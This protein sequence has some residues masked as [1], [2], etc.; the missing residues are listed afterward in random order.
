MFGKVI[1]PVK[2]AIRGGLLHILTGNFLAK[3][4]TMLSAVLIARLVSK[5]LYA[6]YSYTT[7]LYSYVEL[8]NGLEL[9]G[10]LLVFC[11]Q[12]H[13]DNINL[14]WLKYSLRIS[15]MVQFVVSIALCITVTFASIAYPQARG[16]FYMYLLIPVG[17]TIINNLQSF[18][19]A[20][21]QNKL[22]SL[23]GVVRA[24]V[25]TVV[26]LLLVPIL[27]VKGMIIAIYMGTI[28][29]IWIGVK[30][31]VSVTKKSTII[32]ICRGEKKKYFLLAFSFLVANAFSHLIPLNE[33]FLVNELISNETITAN[34]KV[35]GLIPQQ[36]AIIATGICVYFFPEIAKM[37]DFR[38]A[39]QKIVKV[40]LFTGIITLF[41]GIIGMVTSPLVIRILYGEKYL[42]AI[43]MSN[44][45][46]IMRTVDC[47]LRIVPITFLPALGDTKFNYIA[48]PICCFIHLGLDYVMIS[49]FGIEGIAFATILS[50]TIWAIAAWIYL[51]IYCKKKNSYRLEV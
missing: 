23:M 47:S 19:R 18:V 6:Y 11:S 49:N 13:D 14:S 17:T 20:Y 1:E 27:D 51:G 30:W 41:I 16:Y 24:S 2:K 34:F 25:V 10:A 4:I 22:Y 36:L 37:T 39:W 40:G 44:I 35:A 33:T 7:N 43:S 45:L 3:A 21:G 8:I 48:S 15:V 5:E 28:A 50:Y 9:S 38:K 29:T 26:S 31:C 12:S 42:D 46:W 32:N